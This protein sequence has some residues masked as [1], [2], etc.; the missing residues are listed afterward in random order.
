LGL[1]WRGGFNL[2]YKDGDLELDLTQVQALNP[3]A[4]ASLTGTGSTSFNLPHILNLGV[5]FDLTE[6]LLVAVDVDLVMWKSYDEFVVE[7]EVPGI[8]AIYPPGSLN[9]ANGLIFPVNDKKNGK[10]SA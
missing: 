8:E 3:L 6:K 7:I 1:N 10:A 2:D 4:P 9:L 5:A